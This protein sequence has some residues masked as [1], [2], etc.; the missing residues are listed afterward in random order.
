MLIHL[1]TIIA[2]EYD[3]VFSHW[4]TKVETMGLWIE[5]MISIFLLFVIASVYRWVCKKPTKSIKARHIIVTGGSSGIGL[6]IAIECAKAGAHVTVIA[7]N[8]KN[9]ESTVEQI[10]THRAN[11][12]QKIQYRSMDLSKSNDVV[13]KCFAELEEAIA[14]IYGLINCAGMAICGT[15]DEMSIEDARHLMDVNYY[16]TLYPTR[17]VLRQLKKTGDGIITITGSQASLVGIYGYG[18]YAAAKFALRGLAET[19]AMEV[20]HTKISITL[21]LPADTDTPGFANENKTKPE[22]TKII[23]GGGG[24]AKPET[25]A[26]RI[27]ADILVGSNRV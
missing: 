26:K 18:S 16:A 11:S 3:S 19:I 1:Q 24:L 14:P 12:D 20:S 7:R 15:V 22:E 4:L 23:S 17:Y 10:I 6:N 9:L 8:V 21:A 2:I 27:F 5:T 13:E 25:I